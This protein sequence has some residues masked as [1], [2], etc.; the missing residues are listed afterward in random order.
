[1]DAYIYELY[2]NINNKK[3]VNHPSVELYSHPEMY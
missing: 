3:S 2:V 1:M